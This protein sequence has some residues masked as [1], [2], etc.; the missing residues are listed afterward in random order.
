MDDMQK[1]YHKWHSPNLGK[2]MELQIYGHYGK[3]FIIF[4]TSKGRF[5]D[6]EGMGMVDQISHFIDRGKIKLFALDSIDDEALYNHS[7]SP[8]DRVARQEAYY[9]YVTDEV[10]PLIRNHCASPDERPMAAGVSMGAYHAVNYFLKYPFV[11]EGTIALSGLYRL[12]RSEFGLSAG[13]IKDVYFNSPVHYLPNVS[14]NDML[15]WYR[16]SKIVICVGQGAWEEEAIEDTRSLD[17]SFKEKG[18]DAWIDYWGKD[19]NHDWPWWF[20]QMNYFLSNIY[21]W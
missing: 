21:G 8:G 9:K 18:V 13:D 19:V 6:F 14:D 16:R 11:C 2:N 3:P 1:E 5:F 4:P 17:H 7:V 10:V 12:D 15:E 20:K